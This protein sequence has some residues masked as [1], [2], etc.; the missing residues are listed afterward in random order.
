M[1][2]RLLPLLAL[3]L[4][5]CAGPDAVAAHAAGARPDTLAAADSSIHDGRDRQLDSALAAFRASLPRVAALQGGEESRDALVGRFVRALAAADTADLRAMMVTR[6]EFAWLY[7][8]GSAH[9]RRPA[10]QEAELVWFL[11]LQA[12]AKGLS[13]ALGRFGAGPLELLGHQCAP[14]PVREG[15][16]LIWHDCV[17]RLRAGT[18][19]REI[20]LFG[21]VLE[22]DGAFKVLSFANDL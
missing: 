6:A 21:A 4:A 22:R 16:N 17:L 18:R 2:R 1:R 10:R 20:R 14:T 5:A 12:S 7:Y 8:P 9:A 11:G 3:L 15:L 13:R 19:T